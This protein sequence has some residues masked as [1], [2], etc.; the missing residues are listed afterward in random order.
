MHLNYN[1]DNYF[2]PQK[3]PL[4][5]AICNILKKVKKSYIK[6]IVYCVVMPK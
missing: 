1:Y 5:V 6:H 2:T 4:G 3:W